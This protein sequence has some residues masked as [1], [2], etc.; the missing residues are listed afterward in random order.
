MDARKKVIL[1]EILKNKKPVTSQY[2]S[3][4]VGVSSRTIRND[5]KDLQKELKGKSVRIEI[6]PGVGY[7]VKIVKDGSTKDVL[8]EILEDSNYAVV[9]L[10]EERIEYILKNLLYAKGFITLKDLADKLYVSKTT[11]ANDMD[12]VESWLKAHN[13]K[14][15]RKPNY[16]F[17]IEG[18]EIDLRFALSDYLKMTQKQ[19]SL[20]DLAELKMIF[21]NIDID[22]IKNIILNAQEDMDYKL[23]D[24]AYSNLVVHIAI[25]IKR[26]KQNKEIKISKK[27]Y[28]NI[29]AKK[30]YKT[31]E[32]IVQSLEKSF[33]VKIA[34]D[35]TA[36]ITVYLLGMKP[37]EDQN[38]NWGDIRKIAGV[39][40]I[41]VVEKIIEKVD[42]IYNIG[43]SDDMK[44]KKGLALHLKPTLNRLVYNMK[45]RNPILNEIKHQYQIAFDMAIIAA[46]VIREE[47][48]YE[49]DENEIG[50]IAMYFGAAIERKK[51]NLNNLQTVAI[52]CASGM[53]TAQLLA[54]KVRRVFPWFKIIGVY[55]LYKLD[56]VIKNNPDL[57]LSTVPI[58]ASN[59]KVIHVD[60]LLNKGD[61]EKIV[62]VIHVVDNDRNDISMLTNL[63]NENI[64]ETDIGLMDKFDV[65]NYLSERL[66]KKGYVKKEFMKA[67]IDREMISS[68][69]IGNLIAVPHAI[70]GNAIGSHIAV[71]ILKKPII[72][73][74]DKVQLVLMLAL[75]KM[76]NEDSQKIFGELFDIVNDPSKVIQLIGAKNFIEFRNIFGRGLYRDNK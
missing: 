11:V 64:F 70:L 10:P 39:K 18:D 59:I 41:D 60:S 53:G 29:K 63:L 38:L 66:Y 27:S 52:V 20:Y 73:G 8:K 37:F 13:L 51:S 47:Y 30:A 43:F 45:L 49:V 12:K 56:E 76:S 15:F 57:I 6:L 1:R 7:S 50:Y 58:S 69:S 44:L 68:T 33:D 48:G 28:E 40:L 17:K 22:K 9:S 14:L 23:S 65:I 54:T 19:D 61:I 35:E 55:P 31:A 5:I 36:Y 32:K 2:L 26:I 67:V 75:E 74:K 24:V 71:G 62:Q 25:A 21:E 16:G 34:D 46:D 3:K 4:L 42:S 72:W